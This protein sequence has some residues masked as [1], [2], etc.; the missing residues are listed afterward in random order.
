[1][2]GVRWCGLTA[3]GQCKQRKNNRLCTRRK[4]CVGLYNVNADSI[5]LPIEVLESDLVHGA[6]SDRIAFSCPP[7]FQFDDRGS[8][9]LAFASVWFTLSRTTAEDVGSYLHDGF[10]S[11]LTVFHE[12]LDFAGSLLADR[13]SCSLPQPISHISEGN[14]V[15]RIWIKVT[16]FFIC[17]YG[18]IFPCLLRMTW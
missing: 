2:Q 15:L 7:L 14:F 9:R 18:D 8:E 3:G 1:M 10:F 17:W 12:S 16:M 13:A 5:T 6:G 4:L 11:S